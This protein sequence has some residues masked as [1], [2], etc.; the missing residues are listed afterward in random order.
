MDITERK[1]VHKSMQ[2]QM[3]ELKRVEAQRKHLLRQ[4][5]TA[6]ESERRR[7]SR[8][9]H[10]H[11]GQQLTG[12]R[13]KLAILR[14]RPEGTTLQSELDPVEDAVRQLDADLDFLARELRP[15]VLDDLG[16]PQAIAN[17]LE[18]WSKHGGVPADF[19][20][21]GLDQNRL[22]GELETVLY[23]VTQEALNNVAKHAKASNVAVL[24]HRNTTHVSL[25]IEDNGSGFDYNQQLITGENGLGLIGM[26]ER[27]ELTGGRLDI[28]SRID[29]GTTVAVRIPV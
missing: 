18:S 22:P 11:L 12:L 8:E 5:V 23:R 21:S 13:M 19:E 27:V 24:L 4:I 17:F 25:V 3:A 28:E 15:A 2:N 9:V 1:E 20:V 7:I 29:H 10:D 16:L 6:Q 14:S 26:R